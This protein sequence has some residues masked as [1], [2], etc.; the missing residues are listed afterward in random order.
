MERGGVCEARGECS[1]L[2]GAARSLQRLDRG[3]FERRL[4]ERAIRDTFS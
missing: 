4:D 3:L 1:V 2:D